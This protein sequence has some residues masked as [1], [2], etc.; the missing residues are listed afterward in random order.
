MCAVAPLTGQAGRMAELLRQLVPILHVRDPDAERA[1]YEKLGLRTTFEGPEYPGFL[2]VG[3]DTVEFGLSARPGA[4][5][6]DN[7]VTWQFQVGD[8]DALVEVLER[9]GIGFAVAVE[10]PRPGWEFRTLTVRS[11]NGIVVTFEDGGESRG[12]S[13]RT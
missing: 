3:N 6:D 2:A 13:S 10:R 1:F 7:G 5:P 8:L 12:V 11:P 4:G 9:E